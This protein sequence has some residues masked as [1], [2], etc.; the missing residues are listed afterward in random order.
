MIWKM[1]NLSKV[2]GAMLNLWI[3]LDT[4]T[5]SIK[6]I[7][8]GLKSGG[9]VV[10]IIKKCLNAKPEPQLK[11]LILQNTQTHIHTNL[12]A[13]SKCGIMKNNK[14]RKHCNAISKV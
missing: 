1:L 3:L 11:D 13:A 10:N 8:K 2:P 9:S 7:R 14:Q 4:F 12:S 6:A 5:I